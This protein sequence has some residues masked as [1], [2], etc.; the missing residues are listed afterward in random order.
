M[1][2]TEGQAGPVTTDW[3]VANTLL[4]TSKPRFSSEIAAKMGL[5]VFQ[6]TARLKGMEL[7]RL[8]VR[9]DQGAWSLTEDGRTLGAGPEPPPVEHTPRRREGFGAVS[10]P[11]DD[12]VRR[13]HSTKGSRVRYLWD[14]G[15]RVD[16]F[17][18]RKGR[19]WVRCHP[20]ETAALIREFKNGLPSVRLRPLS[21]SSVERKVM[22][23]ERLK[24]IN[25]KREEA[26]S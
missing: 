1:A 12:G 4:K 6:I 25:E 13:V 11:Q 10:L 21:G 5:T 24:I 2:G 17:T 16:I 22:K 9:N 8:M 19:Q 18:D 23:A 26:R 7:R 14:H 3:K 20:M 15:N